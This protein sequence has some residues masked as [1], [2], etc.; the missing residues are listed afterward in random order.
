M[1]QRRRVA[2]CVGRA[3]GG[4]PGRGQR[5]HRRVEAP[6]CDLRAH[7]LGHRL[8]R[9]ASGLRAG[10]ARAPLARVDAELRGTP[11]RGPVPDDRCVGLGLRHP[12]HRGRADGLGGGSIEHG[13]TCVQRRLASCPAARRDRP[14]RRGARR[15]LLLRLSRD[16]PRR[17]SSMGDRRARPA[18]CDGRAE[19]DPDA[20]NGAPRR[21]SCRDAPGRHRPLDRRPGLRGHEP[22]TGSGVPR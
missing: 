2:I 19:L 12:L 9:G 14:G 5:L 22:A 10:H 1:A 15:C 21:C 7:R 20:T 8:L 11:A 18:R 17:R 4:I 16:E 3:K 13:G 6:A